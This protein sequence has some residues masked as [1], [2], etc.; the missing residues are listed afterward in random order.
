MIAS[1]VMCALLTINL[2]SIRHIDSDSTLAKVQLTNSAQHLETLAQSNSP[3]NYR[4]A[5][6]RG[7]D[8]NK[9]TQ[10]QRSLSQWLAL[11]KQGTSEMQTLAA[12]PR[13][14]KLEKLAQLQ[15]V[16]HL[17]TV[18]HLESMV[19]LNAKVDQI[20]RELTKLKNHKRAINNKA[21]ESNKI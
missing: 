9:E 21:C 16:Q 11:E 15:S 8:V 4:M 2:P 5:K 12:L 17:Q 10:G 18:R 19:E 13:A 6:N 1:S 3:T 20:N 7:A 14:V